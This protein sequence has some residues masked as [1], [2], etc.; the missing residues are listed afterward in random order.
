MVTHRRDDEAVEVPFAAETERVLGRAGPARPAAADQQQ[1]LV[2]GVGHRV[3]RLGQH[4]CRPGDEK[5]ANLAMGCRG[6][7]RARR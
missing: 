6:W 1:Y 7:P 5:A 4:R 3:D 2:P